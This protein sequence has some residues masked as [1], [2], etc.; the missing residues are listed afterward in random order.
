MNDSNMPDLSKKTSNYFDT[1]HLKADLKGLS[2]RGGAVTM[3]AQGIKFFL[4]MGSI[5]VLAR[6][7]TP[8]DYGLVAMVAVVANFV[9]MFKDMGLSMATVQKADIDHAQ[10]STL[11]WINIAISLIIMAIMAALAPVVAWFY[12][13]SELVLVTLAL[14]GTFIFGG[15]TI[16]HQALLRRQMYFGKLAVIEIVAM[17]N[18]VIAAI[19]LAWYGAGYWALV[20]MQLV[21][22][23]SIAVG[24]WF[25]CDWRPSLP[26]RGTGVRP[27]LA[28]G[29]DFTGFNFINYF[30]RNLDKIL[31]GKFFGT[32]SLG[33]Y[34]RAY[35][36][37]MLPISQIR[38]PMMSIAI[39]AM[40]R[41]QNDPEQFK[42]YYLKLV[43]IIAFISMP[44]MVFL[45]VCSKEVICVVLGEKW[46]GA[47]PIFRILAIAA[48]I[49]PV[50]TLWGTV[51]IS[52]G[53]SR[54]FL[55][56][57]ILHAII[58]VSSFVIGLPWGP[59]GIAMSYALANYILVL[60]SC[61]YCFRF[62]PVSL[63]I[64]MLA[65]IKPVGASI[66]AGTI[67]VCLRFC[68]FGQIGLWWIGI[69]FVSILL[70]YLLGWSLMPGGKKSLSEYAAYAFLLVK[71]Q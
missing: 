16:Q 21:A 25:A 34:S 28:F 9:M 8:E 42:R 71:K 4:R 1:E 29:R 50:A 54:R 63:R 35:N 31:L 20:I 68:V 32:F 15:L 33:L 64:F 62:T 60:P 57:G 12:G 70:T 30:A 17:F 65:I 56:W 26:K 45:V 39:P 6:L 44:L 40:S 52:L 67:V 47:V 19:I 53:Q 41:L 51:L 5:V 14:A 43:S 37:L 24:V 55:K 11:F 38:T 69:C 18:S 48:F 3:A 49:Q 27:M 23:I 13:K 2:V 10:I 61:W 36:I 22:A 46:L 66:F 7:L 58:M 59:I